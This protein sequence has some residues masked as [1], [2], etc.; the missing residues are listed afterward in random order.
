MMRMISGNLVLVQAQALVV[1]FL[2][3]IFAMVMGW[4]PQGK[5]N[6]QHGLLLCASS[7]LTASL[8]SLVLGVLM[9][10]VV[11]CSKKLGIN[12][13]NVATPVAASLGDLTTLALLAALSK[14]VFMVVEAKHYWLAP[15][16]MATLIYLFLCLYIG[17]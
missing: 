1:G 5:W 7:M 6:V 13:D 14:L 17:V 15:L 8:A 10:C 11:L 16:L 2:A 9:I 3:A 12:P 4:I